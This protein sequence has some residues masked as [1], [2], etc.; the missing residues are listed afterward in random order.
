MVSAILYSHK[1]PLVISERL[2]Q[3]L[4]SCSKWLV[5]NKLSLR[6]GNTESILFGS[7]IKLK[8]IKDFSVTCS[9]QA[10]INTKPVKYLSYVG[11]ELSGEATANE[12]INKVSDR[13]RK[14]QVLVSAGVF[15]DIFHAE[16]IMLFHDSVSF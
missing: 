3:E 12:V 9:G 1:D 2:G 16:N 6:L 10:I 4:E 11:K 15:F 5:D 7:K 13:K 8:K 14:A